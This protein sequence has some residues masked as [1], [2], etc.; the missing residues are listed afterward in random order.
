VVWRT[1]RNFPR[2]NSSIRRPGKT[3]LFNLPFNNGVF[4]Y[5][6]LNV[7]ILFFLL[8]RRFDA[9]WSVDMDTLPAARIVGM[10]K[11]KPVIFDGH[12]FFSELPELHK[13]KLVKNIWWLLEKTFLPGSNLFYTVSPGLVKLYK[14]RFNCD[15]ILLRNLPLAKPTQAIPLLK[16]VQPKIL[17]QGALNVGRGIKQT[18]EALKYL[19]KFKFIIVGEGDCSEELKSFTRNLNLENQVE[20]I[21]AVPFE[22]LQKYQK[23]IMIGICIY[24]EMGLNH[25][26]SLPNRIFDYMQ[27]GIPVISSHFPDMA[28]IV[29]SNNTGLIINNI[30]PKNVAAAIREACENIE[31][32]KTWQTTIPMAAAKFIWENEEQKMQQVKALLQSNIV[33]RLN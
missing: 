8:F 6:T 3:V 32:R 12:E 30:E 11:R 33:S 29:K 5:F 13:R 14:Q 25:Y 24:E 7:Y 15:F 20:F 21:G 26:Y 19:P 2:V 23:D 16:S 10:L 18:I 31:I 1:G 28:D 4:F 17:Y 22:E 9:I 27:A